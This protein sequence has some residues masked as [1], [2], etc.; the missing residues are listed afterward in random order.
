MITP[1]KLN[2]AKATNYRLNIAAIPETQFW[3]TTANIPTISC[4]EVPIPNPVHGYTY[5]PTTTAIWAPMTLTFLVDE[6]FSNYYEL[7]RWMTEATDPNVNART[8]DDG[9][10]MSDGS[11]HILS[12]NKN[13]SDVVFTFKNL[14]PTILGELQFNNESSE[15]LVTDVTLMFDYMIMET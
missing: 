14:F 9:D 5:R 1:R 10:I 12:N 2:L 13:V 11:L 6:D 3:L 7:Y 8:K 15:E 4:N